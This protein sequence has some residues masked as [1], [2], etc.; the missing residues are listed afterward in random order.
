VSHLKVS[1]VGQV[2]LVSFPNRYVICHV[3]CHMSYTIYIYIHILFYTP[4][5]IVVLVSF[6]NSLDLYNGMVADVEVGDVHMGEE[7]EGEGKAEVLLDDPRYTPI[8]PYL[9]HLFYVITTY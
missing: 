6:P 1:S 9:T 3:I 2:V 8:K 7:G 5:L 4:L